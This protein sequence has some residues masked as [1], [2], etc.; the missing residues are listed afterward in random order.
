MKVFAKALALCAFQ[1]WGT[2]AFSVPGPKGPRPSFAL[3]SL[4]T[5]GMGTPQSESA[6][7]ELG[8]MIMER[9]EGNTRRTWDF[10]DV[11]K[12]TVQ[13]VM[14]SNG[15]P[16]NADIELWIGPDWT[17]YK[18]KA[19]SE[20]AQLRPVKALVGTRNKEGMVEV[21]NTGGSEFP[22]SAACAYAKP[23][24]AGLRSELPKTSQSR[25]VEGGAVYVVPFGSEVEQVQVLLT[26]DT[27]Q[28]SAK[29][30]LLNGKLHVHPASLSC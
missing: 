22:L 5:A 16:V 13:V 7:W 11:S 6:T 10:G 19:Y 17:P 4:S 9:I 25:Y 27:R 23:P 29:V 18:L 1:P 12:D 14:T 21:R 20:D 28:L 3:N 15:R 2:T 8:K 24:L 30:E 26:T